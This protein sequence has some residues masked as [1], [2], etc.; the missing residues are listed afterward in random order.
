MPDLTP[1]QRERRANLV[2]LTFEQYQKSFDLEVALD[3]MTFESEE[4]RRAVESDPILQ[5]LVKRALASE[6]ESIMEQVRGLAFGAESEGV[7]ASVLE[8]Y[9]RMIYEKRFKPEAI[10]VEIKEWRV[11]GRKTDEAESA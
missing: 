9:G 8:K 7:R 11:I 4:E 3:L 5:G 6:R 10:P 1:E 2:A